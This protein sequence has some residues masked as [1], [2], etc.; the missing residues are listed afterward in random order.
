M[1][2]PLL[3]RLTC[4]MQEPF[5]ILRK[6]FWIFGYQKACGLGYILEGFICPYT[7]LEKESPQDNGGAVYKAKRIR[8]I[9]VEPSG[10]CAKTS[11]HGTSDKT[12]P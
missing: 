2:Y 9:C 5:F 12:T 8:P 10:L 1:K 7:H 3:K 4:I 11:R 6:Y